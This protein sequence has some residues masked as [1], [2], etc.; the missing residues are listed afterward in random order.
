M[1]QDI[2]PRRLCSLLESVT[3]RLLP[4]IP[5]A[6]EAFQNAEASDGSKQDR[7]LEIAAILEARG[8]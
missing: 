6:R 4:E 5:T 2:S 8:I 3:G 1:V 7:W